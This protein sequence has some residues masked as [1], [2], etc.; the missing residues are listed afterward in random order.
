MVFSRVEVASKEVFRLNWSS[1][2][3]AMSKTWENLPDFIELANAVRLPG[4]I[5]DDASQISRG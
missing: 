3:T 2:D 1:W 4:A 5:L